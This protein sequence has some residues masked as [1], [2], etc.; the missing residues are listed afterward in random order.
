VHVGVNYPWITCGH[1]FGPEP[2][3]W[4]D[5]PRD[6]NAVRHT[7][8]RLR[9]HGVRYVRWWLLA[10]GVNYP[11]GSTHSTPLP[12]RF[13][14]DFR[15]LCQACKDT[16][17]QL[18]P[19]L[20]SFEWFL[21]VKHYG[22]THPV[23]QG[24]GDL[25]FA[26]SDWKK[27]I[28]RFFECTLLQLI[29]STTDLS[30]SIFVWELINEPDWLKR[31]SDVEQHKLLYFMNDGVERITAAKQRASI[32]F[33]DGQASW[34]GQDLMRV[35]QNSSQQGQYLHQ[36]HCYPRWGNL[37]LPPHDTMPIKP[38]MLGEFPTS[39]AGIYTLARW[40]RQPS[41]QERL[42]WIDSQGYPVTL[43]WSVNAKDKFSCWTPQIEAQVLK[44]VK[45]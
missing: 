7:L 9:E 44:F 37:T 27:R 19:S 24:K 12:P 5:Y 31:R 34:I 2:R 40:I 18:I 13:V 10:D 25:L 8:R 6:W 28:E 30:D 11:V 38:C 15:A 39:A 1:D 41:L 23:R 33:Y 36:H 14:S 21:P 45:S 16:E 32:G 35:L 4:T 20:L 26:G 29:A 42:M 22:P 17:V 43:L 3:E